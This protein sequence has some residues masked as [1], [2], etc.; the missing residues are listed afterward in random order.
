MKS[1]SIIVKN[2]FSLAALKALTA[3][4][5]L[6]V[7][8]YLITTI[9]LDNYGVVIF[10]LSFV[11]FFN[12]LVDYSFKVTAVREVSL[13]RENLNAIS[14]IASKVLSTKF[15]LL[16][17]SIF[18]GTVII[19][20][21]PAFYKES[22]IFLL[23][24]S[25]VIGYSLNPNWFFIG[26]EK[27]E[28]LALFVFMLKSIHVAAIFIFIQEKSDVW[29]YAFLISAESL[30]IAILGLT[31][32]HYKF[33]VKLGFTSI[34]SIRTQLKN[35]C[36]LFLNQ[37]V[38]NLYNNATTL[39]LGFFGGTLI[40]GA[41]GVLRKITNLLENILG[42]ISNS[43]YPA[44]NKDQENTNTY[45]KVQWTV[46]LL[47]I[48][49]VVVGSPFI[50]EFFNVE[51]ESAFPTLFIL[52]TGI[53]GLTM[54][55]IYGLNHFIVHKKDKLVFY[56]TLVFSIIGFVLAIPTIYLGGIIGAALTVSLTRL[57]IG[58][59]LFWL[60]QFKELS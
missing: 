54:Y 12:T 14:E 59:R 49:S 40:T 45:R 42:I 27:M 29:I 37:L 20:L 32:M 23:I 60:Y 13:V 6:V 35:N 58:G 8:P 15:F 2:I 22:T 3:I 5:P 30:L 51:N 18:I 41:Y 55:D 24:F 1:N 48:T 56:N 38:P 31:F 34:K 57:L 11:A 44:I 25:S 46:S 19:F 53:I 47:M 39:L 9:G 7:I 16:G 36:N 33:N 50:L 43:F 26:I 17:V 10:A 4:F 52:L 21:T 28:Y